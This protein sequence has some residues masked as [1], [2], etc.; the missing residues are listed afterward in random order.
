M[1]ERTPAAL[2]VC[3]LFILFIVAA[4]LHAASPEE[5][6]NKAS[7]ALYPKARQE[8]ELIVYSV[9]DVEHI[10]AILQA[11]SKK[12]PGI[13]TTYWQA[14]NPEIVTRTITEFRANRASVDA[15]LSDNAPPVLRAAGA[16]LPYETVQK[17]A[18]LMHDP[19]MPVV[20]LQVQALTYNT[21]RMKAEELPKSW[22]DVANPKYKGTVAL[23]DPMRAGPLSTQ[24]AALRD[25][26]KDEA[27]WTAFVKGL[28]ALNVPVHRSTSAMFRLVIAGEYAIAMPA[29]LHDVMNEKEKGTP[30]EYIKTA[31]PVVFPRYAAVYAKA[32]HPN[33]AKLLTEWLI[34]AEG[35]ATLD[36]VGR[37][38]SRKGFPSKT[39]IE[40]AYGAG[41]QPIPVHDKLFMEDP[42]KWLDTHVRPIWGK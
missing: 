11:F 35:Q 40:N 42:R 25:L 27:R 30:V 13:K 26:W 16:I 18:L 12:Y 37:E 10:V 20:S 6:Y 36:S 24:L 4:T 41:T 8:G 31:T 14:R 2:A 39:S 5:A 19:T 1:R 38:A 32:P 9:W 3:C 15:I 7:G 21:K 34:S 17:E 23:D 33:T 28:K 22:E 29:L